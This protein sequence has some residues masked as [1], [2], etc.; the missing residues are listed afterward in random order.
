MLQSA[1]EKI[2]ILF[3]LEILRIIS[4]EVVRNPSEE[5]GNPSNSITREQLTES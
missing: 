5:E 4:L 1:M 3:I 2:R